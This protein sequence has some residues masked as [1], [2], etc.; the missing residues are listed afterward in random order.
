MKPRTSRKS[1]SD[2]A[3]RAAARWLAAAALLAAIPGL[4]WAAEQRLTV[5]TWGGIYAEA[6]RKAFF[7]PFTAETGIEIRTDQYSGGLSD[8]RAQVE[9]GNIFWDIVDFEFADLVLACEESLLELVDAEGLP[10]AP[11]GTPAK[12]D[13][14][15]GTLS[16]CGGGGLY[17]S[18][19]YAYNSEAFPDGGPATLEDFF[20]LAKFPGRRGMR[21]IPYTNLEFALMADGVPPDEVYAALATP[22]GV[23][24]AFHKLDSIKQHIV[25]WDVA[26][27]P[28]QMLAA[29]E[30]AMTTSWN[31]R[32]FQ[33]RF[34]DKQPFVGVWNGQVLENGQFGI[35]TGTPRLEAAQQ[36][37]RFASRPDRMAAMSHHIPYSPTRRSA[38]KLVSIH[39][40]TGLEIWPHMPNYSINRQ[41]SLRS[42]SF[43]WR[44]NLEEL[45]D[46]FN[47]WLLH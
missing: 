4:G 39:L 6:S 8:I 24:R 11:D 37:L 27:Q 21:R 47:A 3:C 33:A 29:R 23:D 31:A 43:W 28:L 5:A 35:V 30:V 19:Y 44:D 22:E 41:R 10:P 20:D 7:D 25:W 12:D 2:G 26:A 14:E 18:T 15:E 40:E 17:W 1:S 36:F 46:R 16:D 32:I 13:Y 42:D 9:S 38:S 45:I 34:V